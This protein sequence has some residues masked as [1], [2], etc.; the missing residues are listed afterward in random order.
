MAVKAADLESEMID[1]ICERVRRKLPTAR[2][3]PCE[4]FIRQFYHWVPAVDLS[5]RSGRGRPLVEFE[6]GLL[7]RQAELFADDALDLRERNRPDV[8]LELP[9]LDDDVGRDD[10][11]ARRE[12]LAE[13]DEGRAELLQ[14]LTQAAAAV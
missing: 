12:K 6:E 10:V 4:S 14:H 11:R 3:A 7:D 2:V 1:G 8:V 5:D 13:L 9:Q